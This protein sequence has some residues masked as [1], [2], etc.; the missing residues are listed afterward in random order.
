MKFLSTR[1]KSTESCAAAVIVKGLAD[2]GGLFVPESFPSV[3]DDIKLL[4]N[5]DYA[6]RAEFIISK[7]LSEYD[8]EGLLSAVKE[9]YSKFDGDPAPVT[10]LDDNLFVLEL[11]HG[12]TLAFKDIA[13]TLLPY[14]L[15]KGSDLCGIKEKI[16]VLVAT[17]GDTG[18]AALEGFKNADGIDINVFYPNK[19]VSDM[20]QLQM[21]TQEGANVNV[22]AVNGN[23]DDCQTAVKKLFNDNAFK[24]TLKDKNVVLSSANSIN[25]GRLVP[26]ISYYFS[27]YCDLLNAEEIKMGD[28]VD[29]VVPTGNFGNILAGYY[30]KKMGLPVGKLICASNSNNVLT[31]FFADGTYDANREFFKTI[32][33]SMDIL[34]SSNLER[35][36]FELSGRDASLTKERMDELKSAGKYSVSKR[37]KTLLDQEFYAGYCDEEDCEQTISDVFEE[38]GYVCDPHTA[39]AMNVYGQIKGYY[40]LTNPA[41][42]LS[43]ANAYK[44]PQAV[45]KA[46]TG[47]NVADAFMATEKLYEE[48][49]AE[50]PVAITALKDKQKRFNKVVNKED[51]GQA[52]ID[53]VE[54]RKA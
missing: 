9:A 12:P 52:V 2:D 42:V 22:V 48:T 24:A 25:F 15:R 41:V 23:F 53:F 17:S 32:S 37:E 47:K 36:V 39:V 8:A 26:Q 49:A 16:L 45:L 3:Y 20:Q 35:L 34:I 33:P 28:K 51:A 30:A 1:G 50:I 18:K 44:F 19:G 10:K 7:Y 31:E 40:G 11:F 5:M 6:E 27:A 43:T 13:L 4:C 14:L 29:F 54:E 21:C 46:I 38:Y